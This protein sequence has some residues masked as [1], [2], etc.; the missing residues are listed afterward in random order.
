M[1][2][3]AIIVFLQLVAIALIAEPAASIYT[4]WQPG[5]YQVAETY[6]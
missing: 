5:F 3:I 2:V 1:K 4:T 6:P